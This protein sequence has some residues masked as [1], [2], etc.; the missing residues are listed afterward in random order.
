MHIKVGDTV[1]I[2]KGKDR[3]QN[4]DDLKKPSGTVLRVDKLKRRVIV[5]GKNQVWKHL[6]KTEKNPQGGRS[7]REAFMPVEN[8]MLWNDKAGK[9]ERVHFK[10]VDGRRV[11][12]FKSTNTTL[13]Q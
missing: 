10:R 9:A 12:V 7:Q 11:R 6:R 1:Q 8:V 3:P 4:A 2:I 5:E 13:D